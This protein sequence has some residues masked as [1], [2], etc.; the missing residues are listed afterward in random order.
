[1][2]SFEMTGP[3]TVTYWTGPGQDWQIAAVEDIFWQIEDWL[4]IQLIPGG[5][6]ADVVFEFDVDGDWLG[7]AAHA[8]P[9]PGGRTIIRIA[10][11]VG[12]DVYDTVIAHEFGHHLMAGTHADHQDQGLMAS[13][14][15]W[16]QVWT[17][18]DIPAWEAAFGA[19]DATVDYWRREGRREELAQDASPEEEVAD[20]FGYYL[21][22]QPGADAIEFWAGHIRAGRDVEPH[23]E[24][25][26]V[27]EPELLALDVARTGSAEDYVTA[28]YEYYL[29]WTPEAEGIAFW[30]ARLGEGVEARFAEMGGRENVAPD[31]GWGGA[32]RGP[33]ATDQPHAG[34][35]RDATD[36][37]WSQVHRE[38]D[39]ADPLWGWSGH[40]RDPADLDWG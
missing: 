16:D 27:W 28:L 32:W 17:D 5:P 3:V 2:Y 38:A 25:R 29:G 7:A 23:F 21:D 6:R 13:Y 26:S 30:T 37:V 34:R 19:D 10:E 8:D 14:P 40:E 35:G 15:P 39:G 4:T 20:L 22:R 11:F 9:E 1:M 12:E 33:G 31:P 36:P 24:A 18:Y